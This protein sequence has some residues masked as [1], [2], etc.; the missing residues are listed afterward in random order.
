MFL[1]YDHLDEVIWKKSS[2][3]KAKS[4]V[5]RV[6]DKVNEKNPKKKLQKVI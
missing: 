2:T 4:G 6:A 1:K 5:K 3:P